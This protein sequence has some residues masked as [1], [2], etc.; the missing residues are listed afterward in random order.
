[1]L[2]LGLG[3]LI[4]DNSKKNGDNENA[5]DIPEEKNNPPEEDF[6]FP[7]L[8]GHS[9]R[10][11]S[12]PVSPVIVPPISSFSPASIN[13]SN[14]LPPAPPKGESPLINLK[15][16]P[17]PIAHI[18]HIEVEKIKPNPYQPRRH[19]DEASLRDLASS[20]RD[21]GV[22]Q[23]LTVTKVV[24]D[25]ST[26]AD[27]EYELIAGERRLMASKLAGLERV[28]VI[29]KSAT[30]AKEKL[31][32]AIIENLQ[33]EDLNPI[34]AAR[35]FSKLQ[36][37][38]GMTQREIASRLGKSREVI[39]NSMRL[40][41]LPSYIQVSVEEGKISESQARLLLSIS[42]LDNQSK[43]FEDLIK[44]NLSVR[45]LRSRIVSEKAKINAVERYENID[46]EIKYLEET[47][48]D[49]LGTKVKVDKNG[50]TGKITISFHSAEE[51]KGIIDKV[52]KSR[53]DL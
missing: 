1:M 24:K 6:N 45:E 33:R 20:I 46:P 15:D 14:E 37:E 28:P 26:G 43:L 52:Q 31:E 11:D 23:P 53:S 8:S 47:L 30:P 34:E 25:T 50:E 39:A 40:L 42:N 5:K 22:I 16:E 3:S 38:Y 9:S 7:D 27:V 48:S 4:P 2:G 12:N 44:N 10:S 18:F 41:S 35:A 13:P 21:Y 19:F 51:L 32:L 49:L 36:D 29:I 17:A